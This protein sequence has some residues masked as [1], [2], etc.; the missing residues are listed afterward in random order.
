MIKK[1]HL[2][3]AF[4][5]VMLLSCEKQEIT[6]SVLKNDRLTRESLR[7]RIPCKL[8]DAAVGNITILNV[9]GNTF[10][11][12]F[13][14]TNVGASDLPLEKMYFQT[15]LSA[16]SAYG[17]GDVAAGG[18][19]FAGAPTLAY[20]D[21]HVQDWYYNPT[22]PVDISEYHYLIVMVIVNP[23]SDLTECTTINNV[24]IQ[25]IGCNLTDAFISEINITAVDH[26]ANTF[27]YNFT[28]TNGGWA[29]LNLSQMFF[30]TYVSKD[31]VLGAGD[32]AAGGSIFGS[33]APVLMKD[34]SYNQFW[35]YNFTTPEDLTEYKY[36]II[37]L[38]VW[39]GSIPECNTTNN[40]SSAHVV[41]DIPRSGLVAFY[42]FSSNGNDA[43]GNGLHGTVN[44]A[45]LTADRFGV[46]SNAYGFD[47][48]ND[49]ID[50]GNPS[51]LQIVNTITL[52]VWVKNSSFT[53]GLNMLSKTQT[54]NPSGTQGHGYRLQLTQTGDGTQY[55]GTYVYY[56]G[57]GATGLNF[58]GGAAFTA[59]E[60]VNFTFTLD[61][62]I[63]KWYKNGVEVFSVSNH[64]P[65]TAA[66][67]GNFVI[68]AGSTGVYNFN[69]QIDDVAVYNR[70]L[71]ATEVLQL[72]N[73]NISH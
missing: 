50:A 14:V 68:G 3:T 63:A 42:P 27:E 29:A 4:A 26:V 5:G 56:P 32:M 72:Y 34:D 39:D 2:I 65:L 38:G 49:F 15:Y 36:L 37:Q 12:E 45:T 41:I 35:Y 73:Q 57:F 53:Y 21:S 8:P 69:G 31:A 46:G 9:A 70:V 25:N 16:D 28:V 54:T 11:Y 1:I 62:S 61:G 64:Q 30:Q 66:T 22:K 55:Y 23:K 40:T 71:S 33:S 43:S 48:I 60:W 24:A 7:P 13:T 10:E 19:V 58:S 20:G 59:N 47:G 17:P 51:Q 18:S 67:L 6:P 52:S 44:G